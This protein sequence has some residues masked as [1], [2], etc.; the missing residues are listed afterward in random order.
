MKRANEQFALNRQERK[1]AKAK[2][3]K[4]EKSKQE[5][6]S[7]KTSEDELARRKQ[8]LLLQRQHLLA[9]KEKQRE[10][11]LKKHS[12]SDFLNSR[13]KNKE[14]PASPEDLRAEEMRKRRAEAARSLQETLAQ[15]S[16]DLLADRAKRLAALD[17]RLDKLKENN[18]QV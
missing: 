8:F 12:M 9:K 16:T 14:A 1:Q 15:N 6:K 7:S 17:N 3:A 11:E 4:A 10:N 13:K 2:A 5:S 18:N